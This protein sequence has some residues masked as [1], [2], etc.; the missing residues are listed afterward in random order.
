MGRITFAPPQ[1]GVLTDGVTGNTSDFGS[2]ES[3]FEPW[4]VNGK[5]AA[6]QPPLCFF[7]LT[8]GS[9]DHE[10]HDLLRSLPI[11]PYE[12]HSAPKTVHRDLDPMF[13]CC[14]HSFVEDR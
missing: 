7:L 1:K 10:T 4:S 13:T 12:I 3:R 5:G 11:Q 8:A 9:L 6:Q 2:E 14:E